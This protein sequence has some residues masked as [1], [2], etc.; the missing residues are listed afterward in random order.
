[1]GFGSRQPNFNDLPV[2]SANPWGGNELADDTCLLLNGVAARCADC[3]RVTRN[4][5]LEN[6]LCPDCYKEKH[7]KESPAI[8]RERTKRLHQNVGCA[9]GEDGEAD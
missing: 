1:M 3:H 9:G 6:G 2:N 4:C 8:E 7:G 5:F